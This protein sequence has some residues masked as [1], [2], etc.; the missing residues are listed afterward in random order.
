M[1]LF[2]MLSKAGGDRPSFYMKVPL[3]QLGDWIEAVKAACKK[4]KS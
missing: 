1:T 4:M 2:V 3:A